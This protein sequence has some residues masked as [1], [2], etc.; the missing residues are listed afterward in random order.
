VVFVRL[1]RR[2]ENC[3]GA[4]FLFFFSFLVLCILNV[5]RYF[6]DAETKCNRYLCNINI[7]PLLKKIHISKEACCTLPFARYLAVPSSL[8][9]SANLLV[10]G[11]RG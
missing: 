10:E 2:I 11:E 4:F 3:G 9:S 5:F 6:V 1:L 8:I 7:F